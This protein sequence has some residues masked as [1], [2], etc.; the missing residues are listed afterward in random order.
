M[1]TC[2]T[3]PLEASKLA[4]TRGTV[5]LS[6]VRGNQQIVKRGNSHVIFLLYL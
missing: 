4:K 2:E 5:F 3:K 6:L 1:S